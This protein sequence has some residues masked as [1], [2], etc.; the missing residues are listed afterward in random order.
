M[1]AVQGPSVQKTVASR[2][3]GVAGVAGCRKGGGNVSHEA[4][5]FDIPGLVVEIPSAGTGLA[6]L[7]SFWRAAAHESRAWTDFAF[8]VYRCWWCG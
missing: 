7:S 3:T 8:S 6:A 2:R 1:H 4:E 5:L